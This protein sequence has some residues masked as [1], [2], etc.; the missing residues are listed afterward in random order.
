MPIIATAGSGKEF[1]PAPK[2][3]F[4]G[5]CVDVIDLG[6]V[7]QTFD[8]EEKESHM[9]RILWQIDQKMDDGRYFIV[10][11]R[12]TVSVHPKAN[13]RALLD[14][15]LGDSLPADID[16]AGYDLELLIGKSGIVSVSHRTSKQGK[17]FANVESVIP[18]MAGMP[19][20]KAEGYKRATKEPDGDLPF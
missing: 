6:M 11:N 20:M 9:V 19:E 4:R 8:G 1:I 12:Y 2:G 13:L 7:K 18:L 3:S 10:S 5:V 15:W 17:T 14:S 16:T